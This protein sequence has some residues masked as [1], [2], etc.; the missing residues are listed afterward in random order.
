MR[1]KDY[2]DQEDQRSKQDRSNN[3]PEKEDKS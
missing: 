2:K 3:L 1:K